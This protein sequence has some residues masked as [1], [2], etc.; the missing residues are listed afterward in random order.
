MIESRVP[1]FRSPV[2]TGSAALPA[3]QARSGLLFR[4]PPQLRDWLA[5]AAFSAAYVTVVAVILAP[6]AF[7]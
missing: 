6:S 2:Q 5:L 1:Q 7:F 4:Y 3:R